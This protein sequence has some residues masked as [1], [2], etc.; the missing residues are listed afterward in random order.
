M[1]WLAFTFILFR[2]KL[3]MI[4]MWHWIKKNIKKGVFKKRKIRFG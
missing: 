2:C 3:D 1:N 4:I